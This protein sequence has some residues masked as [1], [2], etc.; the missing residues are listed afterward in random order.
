M[1]TDLAAVDEHI[2]HNDVE[3]AR[4]LL[5]AAITRDPDFYLYHARLGELARDQ[6]DT[7][8]ARRAYERAVAL[9]PEAGWLRDCLADIDGLTRVVGRYDHY[10]DLTQ[11]RRAEGGRRLRG[12]LP[13]GTEAQPL[14]TIVTAVYDNHTTFQRCIDSIRAQTYANV[15]YIIVDGGSPQATLDVIKAND[16]FIDYYISEPDQGIYSAMNKGISLA[17]GE[18]VG[19]LNSDDWHDPE[20]VARSVAAAQAAAQPDI[21]YSDFYDEGTR[22]TARPLSDGIYL[23]NLNVNHCSFLV[24]ATCYDRIGPYDEGLRILSDMV[25]IRKAYREGCAFHKSDF[26][27]F[28][29]SHGG[30]SSGGDLARRELIIRE[31]GDCYRVDFP[32]L[33]QHEAEDLYLLRF[34]TDKL[35]T[36]EATIERYPDQPL[37]RSALAAYV[38]HCFRDRGAFVLDRSETDKLFVVFVRI[39]EALGV[40]ISAIRLET[41]FGLLSDV[42]GEIEAMPVPACGPGGKRILH[43]ATVFSAPSETFIYD[44]LGRLETGSPHTNVML[45]QTRQLLDER[46]FERTITIDWPHY[47]P[48]VIEQIFKFVLAHFRIDVL[49]AHFAINEHRL[50]Q[51]IGDLAF[52]LPTISM[53]HGIDVFVMKTQPTY[54]N[55]LIGTFCARPN[56]AFTAVS[57][58]LQGLMVEAGIPQDRINLLHNTV[59]PRFFEHRKTENF[60]DRSRS[61]RLLTVGRLIAWKG[62]RVMLEALARFCKA[63]TTDVTLTIVYANGD[64]ELAN[65]QEQAK[66]L[67]IEENINFV[68]FVDFSERPDYFAGFDLYLHASTYTSDV[69]R[70]SETFGV[71]VLEAIAAGLPVISSDAGGLPEVLG[72]GGRFARIVPHNDSSAL[73]N[74][75]QQMWHEGTAFADNIDYAN[76]RLA[77]FSAE[78]QIAAL[79]T[80]INKVTDPQAQPREIKVA[81][82]SSSTQ[83]GAGYA[84][85]RLHRGLMAQPQVKSTM[86]TTILHHQN[87][88]GVKFV[89][90]PSTDGAR[91]RTLQPA[92]KPGNTIFT[93]N[94]THI[95]SHDLLRMVAPYDVVNLHF[96]ARFL[97]VENIASLTWSDK[98]VVMTIRDMMPITGG[99]HFFHGCDKWQQSCENCPQIP[100]AETGFPAEVLAAKRANYNFENLTLVTLSRHTREILERAPGFRDC[101]IETIPNSIETDVFRAY[102]KREMRRKFG[103]PLDRKIIGYVPSFSSDVKG[104][105]EFQSALKLLDAGAMGFDPFVMLVGNHTPAIDGIGHDKKALGYIADN[106]ELAMAYSCAD[107]IVVPS[108]EETFSNTTAEAI[109]CGVPV[110]GF[111]TGAIGDLA[112]NGKT[113]HTSTP[114]D[115]AGLAAGITE[116]LTGPDLSA[117]C[118]ALAEDTLSFMTQAHSYETLYADLVSKAKSRP[119][120]TPKVFDSFD[121]LGFGLSHIATEVVQ[122]TANP[123]ATPT[124][125]RTA[126]LQPR[127]AVQNIPA[128]SRTTAAPKPAAEK[129]I[130]GCHIR[131]IGFSVTND[132][133]AY[134]ESFETRHAPSLGLAKTSRAA[135]GGVTP[136]LMRYLL[137]E[138]MMGDSDLVVLELATSDARRFNDKNRDDHVLSVVSMVAKVLQSGRVPVLLDL[139]RAD[140]DYADDW[141]SRSHAAI[142]SYFGI[143][144]VDVP[145][146]TGKQ[147]FAE[148]NLRDVVHPTKAGAALYADLVAAALA[149]GNM[150]RGRAD[151]AASFADL[152]QAVSAGDAAQG[153]GQSGYLHDARCYSVTGVEIPEGTTQEFSFG[154]Q[155]WVGGIT[156]LM[157]PQSGYLNLVLPDEAQQ[158]IMAYDTYCYYERLGGTVFDAVTADRMTIH[159]PRQRPDIALR[160]GTPDDGPRCGRI[161]HLLIDRQPAA[162]SSGMLPEALKVAT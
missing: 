102:D 29:F 56:T 18:Y 117:N 34:R 109:S 35:Q 80:V 149:R 10:P 33:T 88:P 118:R 7:D 132:P 79:N 68:P 162:L 16:D 116:L 136:M 119:A 84:A 140:V 28:H 142:A 30:L 147:D 21:V 152:F 5:E 153:H 96:H 37:F 61:L 77:V 42:L 143:L 156:Y 38:E 50:F 55:H 41:N 40:P 63:C 43:Y 151:L 17:R 13:S 25:W 59:N 48:E 137:D 138:Q 15:E 73:T 36:V 126:V 44:L 75:L 120:A 122:K 14:V 78:N 46:P 128:V 12:V 146:K 60:Y 1:S 103:L 19:L 148:Q 11:K 51:R 106:D 86:F 105:H 124:Q 107:V 76:D 90:H 3:A 89:M 113:G 81:L 104:Y 6:G 49:V 159:Q 130:A 62:H 158:Q 67:A 121:R 139:P 32:F 53:C 161:M 66:S 93:V 83:Q 155:V 100:S 135:I 69:T 2:A 144:R 110:A 39:A 22:V 123:D 45:C 97:S 54:R 108:L 52:G 141:M 74:E 64:E 95:Q 150:A 4:T 154:K 26:A 47:R 65:L 145:Q 160:K 131:F 23:G 115:V 114:G 9:N 111:R 85:Y 8:R 92:P 127:G 134:S 157:A 94:Q 112:L 98:P 82:L 71:A 20:F 99:C 24:H 72:E 70:K 133:I 101:R 57:T 31:N 58:Y 91:W 129:P 87:E 27:G 125:G